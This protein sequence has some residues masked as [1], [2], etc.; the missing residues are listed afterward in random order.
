MHSEQRKGVNAETHSLESETSK[1]LPLIVF[2]SA[3]A[4]QISAAT[5]S[6]A[7]ASSFRSTAKLKATA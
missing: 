6:Q 3:V 7:Y 5:Q 1:L 2:I 4:A